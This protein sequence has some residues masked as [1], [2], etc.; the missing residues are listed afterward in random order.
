MKKL[1]AAAVVGLLLPMS[2]V[3]AATT[4]I[5]VIDREFQPPNPAVQVGDVVHWTSGGG[6]QEG[7]NVRGGTFFYSGRPTAFVDFRTT[8]SAGTF[9]YNCEIHTRVMRGK[10][11]VPVTVTSAP[12]GAKFTVK[13][14]TTSTKTGSRFDIQYRIGSGS[15]SDWLTKTSALKGVFGSA[16]KPLTV[17]A[18]T[19]YGFRARSRKGDAKS[20]WSP[21]GAFT[22]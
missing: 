21:I 17:E 5:N 3:V 8:F 22:T 2:S 19:K 11:Q 9:S 10:V 18:G 1:I 7:H 4:D 14:A 15:W 16:S 13:W 20:D 6:T 12:Q